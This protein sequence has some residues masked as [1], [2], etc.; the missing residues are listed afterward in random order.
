M[1]FKKV[2][3]ILGLIVFSGVVILYFLFYY[4]TKPKSDEAIQEMFQEASEVVQLEHKNF[5]GFTYRKLTI[6][7]NDSLPTMVFVHGAIGSCVDFFEYMIDNELSINYNF[8]SYDRIGYNYKDKNEVQESIAFERDML[9]DITKNLNKSK[10]ILVGYSY[11]GPIAL[12]DTT[13]Y[14]KIILLAPAVYSKVEP[15]PWMINLYKWKATRWLVPDVWKSASK[16]KMTH[17][18]DLQN[19]ENNWNINKNKIVS[20]HGDSDAIVPLDNSLYLQNHF[21]EQQ[22][23]LLTIPNAGHG[24]VWSEFETIKEIFLKQ[25]D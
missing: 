13:S 9:Q 5:R 4:F 21:P 17:R 15:M 19:F 25:K 16:E 11:G 3:K 24:L 23:E 12:A 6:K 18:E 8:I 1:N 22:F 20:I 7:N 14:K 2:F 10:T